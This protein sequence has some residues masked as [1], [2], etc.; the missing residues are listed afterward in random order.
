MAKPS[1]RVALDIFQIALLMAIVVVY[2]ATLQNAGPALVV[3]TIAIPIAALVL[4]MLIMA[5]SCRVNGCIVRNGNGIA[6]YEAVH[7]YVQILIMV[8]LF[9]FG[10]SDAAVVEMREELIGCAGILSAIALIVS[11]I[12]VRMNKL[13]QIE[14]AARVASTAERDV[15]TV[16]TDDD[17][18]R[19]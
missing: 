19:V 1:V 15:F 14:C 4:Q 10:I 11:R 2:A 17:G 18:D 9:I 12:C 3:P 5:G 16:V 7:G 6:S 13:I 8:S